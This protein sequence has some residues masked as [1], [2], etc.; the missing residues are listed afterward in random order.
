MTLLLVAAG[1]LAQ[2]ASVAAPASAPRR[3]DPADPAASVPVLNHRS[4]FTGYRP[5]VE[6]PV[7]AWRE[8]ND[9]V[10]RIGGWRSY[11]R[12]AQS[13]APPEAAASA[14]ATTDKR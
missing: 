13:T 5:N 1:A 3:A 6:Q 9:Q 7:G 10:G 4:A 14:P 11:A 2:P 8:L 12:E